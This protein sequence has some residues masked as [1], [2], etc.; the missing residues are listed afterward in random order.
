[1]HLPPRAVNIAAALLLSGGMIATAYWLSSPGIQTVSAVSTDEILRAYAAKDTDADGLPDWQEALY[2]TDVNNPRS[3]TPE[4]TDAEAVAQGLV[5]PQFRSAELGDTPDV[6]GIDAAPETLTDQFGRKFLENYIRLAQDGVVTEAELGTFIESATT[7]LEKEV[8]R[9]EV[10][11]QKDLALLGA[12]G[13]ALRAYA[14][15]VEAAINDIAFPREKDELEY[16]SAAMVED[17]AA[18]REAVEEIT[19][20]Y[21]Q[22]ADVLIKI[23]A[24]RDLQ[25]A[26]PRLANSL[27]DTGEIFAHIQAFSTDPLRGLVGLKRYDDAKKEIFEAY[28]ALYPIFAAA[29][30]T[31]SAEEPGYLFFASMEQ[32]NQLK[33]ILEELP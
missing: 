6:P 27:A 18:A 16:V 30:V 25:Y 8:A 28:A 23:P 11:T 26:A 14:I 19:L 4:M 7:E 33:N 32:A 15:Q 12:G 9:K 17:S 13:E 1:M 24:P 29:A 3:V 31:I 20:A 10:Y 5:A 21:Q 22:M 2:G